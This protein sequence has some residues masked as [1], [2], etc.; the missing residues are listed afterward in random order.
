MA[1]SVVATNRASGH[2]AYLSI[3][4]VHLGPPWSRSWTGSNHAKATD[5]AGFNFG[6][7][8][9]G[10]RKPIRMQGADTE[11]HEAGTP[12]AWAGELSVD[13]RCRRHLITDIWDKVYQ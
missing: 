12:E 3:F 9:A 2:A 4:R 8:G 11:M 13:S 10:L 6:V 1:V 7:E 5:A